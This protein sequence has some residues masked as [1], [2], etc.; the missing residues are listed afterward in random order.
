M[1]LSLLEVFGWVGSAA[2]VFSLLQSNML[3]LRTVSLVACIMVAI[4]SALIEAWPMVGM[5]GA[6]ALINVYFLVKMYRASRAQK[7]SLAFEASAETTAETT[8]AK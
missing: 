4:Y 1:N 2:V 8:A 6:I 3:R 5:N 7:A